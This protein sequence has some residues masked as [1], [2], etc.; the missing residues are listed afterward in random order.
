MKTAI[1]IGDRVII[2]NRKQ[3]FY[4]VVKGKHLFSYDVFHAWERYDPDY[5]ELESGTV[6]RRYPKRKV[7]WSAKDELE[8]IYDKDEQY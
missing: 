4:G 1:G 5:D 2:S 7:F 3:C 8:K 6:V